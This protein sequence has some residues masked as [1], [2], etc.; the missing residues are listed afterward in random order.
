MEAIA[1]PGSREGG[2]AS[3]GEDTER[4]DKGRTWVWIWKW[5]GETRGVWL[6]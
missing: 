6:R 3:E 5:G 1:L 2:D 4:A